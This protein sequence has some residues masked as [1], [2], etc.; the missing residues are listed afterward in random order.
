MATKE[1][2]KKKYVASVT[3]P[4]AVDKMTS[5]LGTY[6][7]IS[8]SESAAPIVNYKKF[9]GKADDYFDKLYANQKIAYGG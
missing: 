8:V 1:T 6:L 5:K 4:L 9:A 2:A 7:G 3:S